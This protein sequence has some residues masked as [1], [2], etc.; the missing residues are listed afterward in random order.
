MLN[1]HAD[2]IHRVWLTLMVKGN[3]LASTPL[4]QRSDC[5]NAGM[6]SYL[7]AS[8]MQRERVASYPLAEH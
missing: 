5:P 4:S 3:P 7:L 2:L 8:A 6:R 1:A